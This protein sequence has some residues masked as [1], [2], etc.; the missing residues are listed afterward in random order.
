MKAIIL[1]AG[2]GK[3]LG[4]YTQGK[5]KCLLPLG[6][7]TILSRE[8]RLL[9]EAGIAE[10]DIYV[11]GGYRYDLLQEH[12]PNLIVN[13]LYDKKENSYSLGLALESMDDDILILD[14]D[15]C[16]EVDL[17]QELLLSPDPNILMSKV[18][19]DLEESTGIVTDAAGYVTAIGKQYMNTGLVYI[20]I[21]K[22]ARETIPAFREALLDERHGATW[23]TAAIT[24][25]CKEFPFVNLV[26][27]KKWHEIDFVEDYLETIKLFGLD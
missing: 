1:A 17:L 22:I 9:Q 20:S 11:V 26:T 10:E 5:P 16:F 24:N 19:D 13:T 27:A 12:V 18:S 4:Q 3:R 6:Q 25:I 14:A 15:L 21:F 7:E 8:V 23:Y 2:Q